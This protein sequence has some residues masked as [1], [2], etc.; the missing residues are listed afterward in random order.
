MVISMK[1]ALLYRWLLL[2]GSLV[3][4][5]HTTEAWAQ[6][7]HLILA[8]DTSREANLGGDVVADKIA[9]ERLFKETIPE[10]RL[11]TCRILG[12]ELSPTKILGTVRSLPVER[13]KDAIVVYYSGHGAYDKELASLSANKE[14]GE[15]GHFFSL[16]NKTQLLRSDLRDAIVAKEPRT[17]VIVTDCCAAGRRFQGKGTPEEAV[18]TAANIA[19]IFAYLLFE[20]CGYVSITSSDPLQVSLTRGDGKG[21]VFTYP[22]V[23]YLRK[24]MNRRLAWEDIL[25]AVGS[26]VQADFNAITKRKGV[27]TNGDGRPDQF[28][29][30]VCAFVVTPALG[31]RVQARQDGLKITEIVPLSPAYHAGLEVGDTLLAINDK[32]LR[33]QR[34]YSDAVDQSPRRMKLKVLDHRRQTEAEVFAMLN[35]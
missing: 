1:R 6:R 8:C 22:F 7:V 33:T 29:Q 15:D 26:Q 4:L 10:A 30:T 35:R 11:N 14:L 5:G 31:M 24:N 21:S 28:K 17:A 23:T 20:R 16:P 13:D 19:P 18:K 9:I 3:F 12:E 32:P 27:D 2:A 34:A 25:A